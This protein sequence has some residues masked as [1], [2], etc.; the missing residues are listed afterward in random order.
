LSDPDLIT[1]CQGHYQGQGQ[2]HMTSKVKSLNVIFG[3]VA[4]WKASFTYLYADLNYG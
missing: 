3:H 4:A 1:S 2:G